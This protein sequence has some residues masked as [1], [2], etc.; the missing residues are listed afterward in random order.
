MKLMVVSD[1]VSPLVYGQLESPFFSG[2]ELVISCG[3]LPLDYLEY[4]ISMLNVPCYFVPGNHDDPYVENPPPGWNALDGR[5]VNHDGVRLMGFGGSLSYKP[6]AGPY[7]YSEKQ[8]RLRFLKLLPQLWLHK[9]IDIL[10]THAPPYKL[11]DLEGP[12]QGFKVFRKIIEQYEPRYHLHGHVHL[13]YSQ[14]PR[15]LNFGRTTII[16]G[17]QHHLVDCAFDR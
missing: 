4:I 12:H 17:Y 2:V 3:D 16:N 1:A 11:G 8:M 13:N 9:K 5:I 14:N 6:D 15:I 7:Y 10:V